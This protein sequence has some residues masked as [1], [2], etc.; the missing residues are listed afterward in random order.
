[1]KRFLVALFLTALSGMASA[2]AQC[3]ITT[4]VDQTAG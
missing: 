2:A 1:M 4:A 3:S